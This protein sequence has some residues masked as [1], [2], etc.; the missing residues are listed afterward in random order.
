MIV[1][2]ELALPRRRQVLR[3]I[4]RKQGGYDEDMRVIS[5][6]LA[7]LVGQ[8]GGTVRSDGRVKVT[9]NR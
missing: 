8:F 3:R 4:R 6:Q 5:I 2:T 9:P 1:A 7:D